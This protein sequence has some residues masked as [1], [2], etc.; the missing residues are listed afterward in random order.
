MGRSVQHVTDHRRAGM[1]L[2][3]PGSESSK[4][5]PRRCPQSWACHPGPPQGY[6]GRA[7]S[8]LKHLGT[9]SL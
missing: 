5:L 6:L 7:G 3:P 2:G 9:Y 8:T 4:E 1:S